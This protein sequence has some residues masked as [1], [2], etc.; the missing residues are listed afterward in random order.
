[1]LKTTVCGDSV[2]PHQVMHIETIKPFI[3]KEPGNSSPQ[4]LFWRGVGLVNG[5]SHMMP[6][7]R[8]AS[9]DLQIGRGLALGMDKRRI[10]MR[11]T[12]EVANTVSRW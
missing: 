8:D 9:P 4:D 11:Y 2:S 5:P 1:M 12:A 7:R 10:V 3:K 6:I